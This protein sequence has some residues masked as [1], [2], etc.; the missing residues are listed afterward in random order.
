MTDVVYTFEDRAVK[1]ERKAQE[2]IKTQAV[3]RAN[4]EAWET[5]AVY[6]PEEYRDARLKMAVYELKKAGIM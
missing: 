6:G 2:L 3:H 4:A 1:N 5:M